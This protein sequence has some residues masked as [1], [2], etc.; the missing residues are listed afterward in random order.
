LFSISTGT[1]PCLF[2]FLVWHRHLPGRIARLFW[3]KRKAEDLAAIPC[4][5]ECMSAQ[6]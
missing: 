4:Y 1:A 5:Y 3:I 2:C 6:G